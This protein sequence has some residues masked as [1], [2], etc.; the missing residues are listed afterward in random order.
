MCSS[1][2]ILVWDEVP[3][4]SGTAPS[5]VLG[6]PG[7][8]GVTEGCGPQQFYWPFGIAMGQVVHGW[9][10]ATKHWRFAF[11]IASLYCL[12]G[13]VLVLLFYRPPPAAASASFTTA[14]FMPVSNTSA[15]DCSRAYLPA[16][17]R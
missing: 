16:W 1:D 14:A 8:E 13:A 7:L 11:V 9:L 17:A 10:A 15:V 3:T 12:A 5:M 2:L 6:Q 4:R